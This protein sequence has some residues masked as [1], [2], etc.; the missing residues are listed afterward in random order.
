MRVVTGQLVISYMSNYSL[1]ASLRG[2]CGGHPCNPSHYHNL[3]TYSEDVRESNL[4]LSLL[5]K[6]PVINIFEL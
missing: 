2:V 6:F 4:L 1:V 3:A 5:N